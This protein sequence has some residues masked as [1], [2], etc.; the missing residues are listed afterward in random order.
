MKYLI[1]VVAFVAL[2]FA[3][4]AKACHPFQQSFRVQSFAQPQFFRQGLALNVGFGFQN[5]FLRQRVVVRNQFFRQRAIIQ[6]SRL[7]FPVRSFQRQRIINNSQC[8]IF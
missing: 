8:L 2:S 5:Q 3:V 6:R 1:P 7:A 4:E